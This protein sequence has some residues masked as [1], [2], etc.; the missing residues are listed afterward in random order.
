MSLALSSVKL[1]LGRAFL[2][3]SI[4]VLGEGSNGNTAAFQCGIRQL[5]RDY[6]EDVPA[7][8]RAWLVH[9]RLLQTYGSPRWRPSLPPLEELLSTILSQNTNDLNRDRAFAALQAQFPTW[10]AVRDAPS[11]AVIDAIRPAGLAPQ[12]GPRIQ[13]LLRQITEECGGLDLAFLRQAP[14]EDVYAW[15]THFDGVGP[16]TASIVMLFSLQMPAFPVDTHVYR[17]TGRLGLRPQTITADQAHRVLAEAF[18]PEA[19]FA[20]HLNLIRHG[21]EI[22]RARKPACHACS[23]LDLCDFGRAALADAGRRAA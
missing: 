8:R 9:E 21:R 4:A 10:Q 22:C 23:L 2:P 19:Y 18:P 7:D 15:L 14:P 13:R 1:L 12:K 17:L 5:P 3:L 6:N 11:Q 20:A 16:K